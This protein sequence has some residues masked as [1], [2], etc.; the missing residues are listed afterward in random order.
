MAAKD[1]GSAVWRGVR[2]FLLYGVALVVM[3]PLLRLGNAL[4]SV[5]SFDGCDRQAR[6]RGVEQDGLHFA[7]R[8]AL[9]MFLEGGYLSARATEPT[10]RHLMALPATDCA[11]VGV[12]KSSRKR[13][14]YRVTLHADGRFEAEPLADNSGH[15]ERGAGWWG[16]HEGHMVWVHE[17]GIVWPPDVN[18]IL[19]EREGA[20]ALREVNGERSDFVRQERLDETCPP[21]GAALRK[22]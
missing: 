9:C 8:Y 12:W 17:S 7:Q 11:R 10:L 5:E 4:K 22:Y 18:R 1:E 2:R 21:E 20:F 16:V 6:Y 15:A 3:L 14:V 19:E 13:M